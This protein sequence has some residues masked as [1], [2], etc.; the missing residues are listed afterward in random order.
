VSIDLINY[1]IFVLGGTNQEKTLANFTKHVFA[2]TN[3][4]S[5]LTTLPVF[6]LTVA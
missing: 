6:L 4:L 5:D 2:N 1:V 3:C